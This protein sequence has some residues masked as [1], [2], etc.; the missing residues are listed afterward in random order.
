MAGARQDRDS[1]MPRAVYS[2]REHAP[3]CARLF[4]FC[5]FAVLIFAGCATGRFA[6]IRAD[7]DSH[8]HYVDGVPF[9]RQRES[10][11]GP[12]ALAGVLAFRGKAAD[13]DRIAANIF[14][15][16]LRGTLPMDMESAARSEGVHVESRSGTFEDLKA[17]INR[18][19][20]VICLIDAGIWVYRKPHYVIV[21]GFDD[22]HRVVI[23]HDGSHPNVLMPY[24]A[25][26]EA[27]ERGGRWMLIITP[28][29]ER[30]HAQ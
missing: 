22:L 2:S 6:E 23:V 21:L 9:F 24:A 30:D 3:S 27:W 26:D 10:T 4:L 18:N 1:L 28:S 13:P 7:L 11:C 17:R 20:P 15:P 8:G 5:I 12:V 19:D 14:L 25:F 29:V 16:G